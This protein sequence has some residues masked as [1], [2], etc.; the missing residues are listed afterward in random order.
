MSEVSD[1]SDA[2]GVT[3]GPS[4]P[5]FTLPLLRSPKPHPTELVEFRARRRQGSPHY[6]IYLGFGQDLSAGRPKERSLVLVKVRAGSC[7]G[8]RR[9]RLLHSCLA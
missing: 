7:V 3:P 9:R 5:P 8:R 1:V 4:L 6:T 2:L